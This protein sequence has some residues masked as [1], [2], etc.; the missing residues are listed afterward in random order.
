MVSSLYSSTQQNVKE[1]QP[2]PQ[3]K[4]IIV[5]MTRD[6]PDGRVDFSEIVVSDP[7]QLDQFVVATDQTNSQ[8]YKCDQCDKAF[9]RSSTLQGLLNCLSPE[10]NLHHISYLH[11]RL[12]DSHGVYS[13]SLHR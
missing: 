8:L 6:N 7:K 2:K 3:F 5:K 9:P 4:G 12:L 10:L 11:N 13:L 1:I